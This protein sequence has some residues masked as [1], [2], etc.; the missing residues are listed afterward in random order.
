MFFKKRIMVKGLLLIFSKSNDR[1]R[2]S[3]YAEREVVNKDSY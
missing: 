2:Y 1:K 3:F